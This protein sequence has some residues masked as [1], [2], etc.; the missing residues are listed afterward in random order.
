MSNL[1]FPV[2]NIFALQTNQ[3]VWKAITKQPTKNQLFNFEPQLKCNK[4]NKEYSTSQS[5]TVSLSFAPHFTSEQRLDVS[6]KPIVSTSKSRK[7]LD[8][9]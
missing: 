6:F 9:R 8:M 5:R 2:F 3:L 7:Y 4:E 1:P